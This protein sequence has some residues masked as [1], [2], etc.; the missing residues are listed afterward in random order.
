M[1]LCS[2]SSRC[3]TSRYRNAT[4]GPRTH[5]PLSC[6]AVMACS[7]GERCPIFTS[8]PTTHCTGPSSSCSAS[9]HHVG[10]SACDHVYAFPSPTGPVSVRTQMFS[11]IQRVVRCKVHLG[12]SS[13]ETANSSGCRMA[14]TKA[15]K[16]GLLCL[17]AS[18]RPPQQGDTTAHINPDIVLSW[19]SLMSNASHASSGAPG[20]RSTAGSTTLHTHSRF[21]IC[22][23]LVS[24]EKIGVTALLGMSVC[25]SLQLLATRC[26]LVIRL[27]VA[28]CAHLMQP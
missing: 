28:H 12:S 19:A 21:W 10:L 23:D 27:Q 11:Q 16:S 3:I 25:I 14:A 26:R 6:S 15:A 7:R 8:C 20:V 13:V 24:C 4:V 18:M 1:D 9:L 2:S 17:S 22:A 5:S